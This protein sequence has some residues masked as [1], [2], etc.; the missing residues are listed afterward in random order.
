MTDPKPKIL[1][2][3]VSGTA[4]AVV[5]PAAGLAARL[6]ADLI[7]ASV[8]A[9][10]EKAEE[11][12]DGTVVS[13]PLNPDLPFEETQE[14]DPALQT[15]I[16]EVLDPRQVHWS[17]RALA[18]GPAQEL[19]RLANELDAALI[20]VG[21]RETGFRGSVEEFF[22]GSVAVQLSHRQRRPVVI[23]PLKPVLDDGLLPWQTRD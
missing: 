15:E 21:T 3:V 7:C 14:F 18:G 23:V 2:G 19:G 6:G 20:V 16:A 13:R 12:P 8:D 5:E 4:A 1:V 10:S 22:N 11:K 17:V 9:S